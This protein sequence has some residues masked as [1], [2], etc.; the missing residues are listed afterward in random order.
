MSGADNFS[1]S[2]ENAFDKRLLMGTEDALLIG[3]G[4]LYMGNL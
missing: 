3:N 2:G 4:N 1:I